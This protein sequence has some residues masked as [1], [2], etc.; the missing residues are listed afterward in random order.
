ML[1]DEG[2]R[3]HGRVGADVELLGALQSV[4]ELDGPVERPAAALVELHPHR[5]VDVGGEVDGVALL[6]PLPV[7]LVHHDVEP[8]LVVGRVVQHVD[9]VGPRGDVRV[10]EARGDQLLELLGRVLLD[11]AG[12]DPVGERPAGVSSA[13]LAGGSGHEPHDAA[14]VRR[15]VEVVVAAA[16][17]DRLEARRPLGGG[18]HLHGPEVGDA[19]HADVAIAPGLGGDPLDEVVGV[20]PER[21]ATGVVVADV[22]TFGGAGASQVADD[23]DV[24]LGHHAGDVAGLD[25]AVPHRAG[26]PLRRGGQGEGLELLAVGAQG[27]QR[28]ARL[29]VGPVVGVGGELDAVAHRHPEVLA[30]SDLLPTGIEHADV[31]S[32]VRGSCSSVR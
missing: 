24:V 29:V 16:D 22:L 32:W 26:S 13:A 6:V 8:H 17:E 12:L 11:H 9:Q 30:D 5:D 23:V 25:A 3:L 1:L 27:H 2:A 14:V 19:D 28:G 20:L 7:D 31:S 18:E 21:D 4:E 15:L 10:L